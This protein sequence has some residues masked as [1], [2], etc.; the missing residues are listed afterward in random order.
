MALV[1]C[2]ASGKTALALE[3]ARRAGDVEIVTVDS[4]Q[5]YRGMDIGTAK[6]TTTEQG[7]VPHHLLD[8]ADPWE[9]WTLARWLAA[10]RAAIADVEA[11]G[12]IPLL[13]GGTALYFRALVDGLAPPGTFPEVRAELGAESDT[14]ALYR[15]LVAVDPVGASRMESTNRR[16][17]IRALEVTLGSGRPFSSFGPG[18]TSYP[19]TTW[20]LAGV[21]LSR[22]AVAERIERRMASMMRGGLLEETRQLLGSPHG[23]SRTARQALGYKELIGHLEEG[24][25]L[26]GAVSEAV[27][28]TRAFSRRQR[29]W[30]RRDPRIRWYGSNGNPLAVTSQILGDWTAT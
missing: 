11:R 28:R 16:R 2:T 7:E 14:P 4:M 27:R 13:V 18:L 8:L 26:D 3:L 19:S 15:R 29:M 1:G 22:P 6:P 5:V 25:A 23:L 9:E 30:W 21:W 12:R 17:V 24:V 10:A 20:R